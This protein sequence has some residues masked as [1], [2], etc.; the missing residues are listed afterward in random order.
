MNKLINCPVLCSCT[1]PTHTCNQALTH[2]QQS[3]RIE[4]NINQVW[5]RGNTLHSS[6]SYQGALQAINIHLL[7]QSCSH[8]LVFLS[9]LC[10]LHVWKRSELCD[11]LCLNEE[12]EKSILVT[13]EMILL[14]RTEWTSLSTASVN[15]TW[16]KKKK[17]TSFKF[18]VS[19]P[20]RSPFLSNL[21]MPWTLSQACINRLPLKYVAARHSCRG[22][23]SKLMFS[24]DHHHHH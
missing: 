17:E 7:H 18:K 6:N 16:E 22:S 19:C 5:I 3:V 4:Q 23:H 9:F 21:L 10:F 12:R 11:V 15:T 2:H 8:A 13:P 24:H 20:S 1:R 14:S